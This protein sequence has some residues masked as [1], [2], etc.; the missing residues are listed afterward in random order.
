M[1]RSALCTVCSP[2]RIYPNGLL[3][4]SATPKD[5]VLTKHLISRRSRCGMG[6]LGNGRRVGRSPPLLIAALTTCILVLAFNYWVSNSRIAELQVSLSF[7]DTTSQIDSASHCNKLV[8]FSMQCYNLCSRP[9]GSDRF[10]G[11][12]LISFALGT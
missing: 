1:N 3:N 11:S 7:F 5:E 2:E 12:H 6:A 4:F 9:V 10:A 8:V